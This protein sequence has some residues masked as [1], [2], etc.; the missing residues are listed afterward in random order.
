MQRDQARVARLSE[1]RTND[2]ESRATIA[3]PR[4]AYIHVPFCAHRCGYCNFSVVAGRKDLVEPL[5]DAIAVEL[6]FLKKPQEVDTLYFGGGTPTLLSPQQLRRLGEMVLQW[7]PLAQSCGKRGY[8][9]TVEANPGDL[10]RERV[11]TL[12]QLG[13][14]RISLGAQSFRDA[15]LKILERDHSAAQIEQAVHLARQAGMAVSL[16]LIFATPDENLEQWSEDLEQ[17][18]ALEPEH[19]S[20]YGLTYEK[21]TAYWSRRL[22][23]ELVQLPEELEREMYLLAIDRLTSAGY[24]HYEISNFARPGQRSRHN[25]SCWKGEGYFAVGPGAARYVDGVRETNHRS[26]TTY[27]KYIQRGDSPVAER[28]KLGRDQL[29]HERL[30]FGLRRLEGIDRKEFA[31]R[32]GFDVDA[33]AGKAISRLVELGMLSDD[34]QCVRL[35]REG[36]F[37]SDAIWPELL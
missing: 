19:I 13:V 2:S 17:A 29:A 20:A 3:A 30:I 28:E 24:E 37:V 15:K 21:G 33:L 26:T 27:L 25:E 11:D 8:E 6:S 18:I 4:S 12:A 5:L 22:H 35:T 9:W 1:S 34:G 14:N 32:S 23:G 10:D 7:H 36:L 16:D 31:A